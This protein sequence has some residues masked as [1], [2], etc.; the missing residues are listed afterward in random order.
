VPP[1]IS[2]GNPDFNF[3]RQ[4]AAKAIAGSGSQ[5][6]TAP[7]TAP[8]AKTLKNTKSTSDDGGTPVSLDTSCPS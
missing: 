6:T 7:S 4:R 5:P 2:T 1:L 8:T 3:I